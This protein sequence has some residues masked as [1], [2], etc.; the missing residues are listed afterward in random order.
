MNYDPEELTTIEELAALFFSIAD[1]AAVLEVDIDAFSCDLLDESSEAYKSYKKG[2]MTSEIAL[3]KSVLESATNGSN[4]AQSLMIQY[5]KD[6]R[7]E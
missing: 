1:I 4:P 7:Y 3:R 2:W 5:N 6:N